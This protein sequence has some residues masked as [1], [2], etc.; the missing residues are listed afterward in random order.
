MRC[1]QPGAGEPELFDW[2]RP[3]VAAAVRARRDEVPWPIHIDQFALMGRVDRPPRPAIWLY[4]HEGGGIL[5]VDED[6][7]PYRFVPNRSGPGAGRFQEVT[8]RQAVWGA[9]LPEHVEPVEFRH[10]AGPAWCDDGFDQ[11]YA[12][13]PTG[14]EPDPR[15]W[16]PASASPPRRHRSGRRHLRLVADA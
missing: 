1:W 7:Q 8:I 4:Q 10:P 14:D 15:R 3:L 6:G 13:E 9:C 11:A 5:P 16:P 12:D 2:W